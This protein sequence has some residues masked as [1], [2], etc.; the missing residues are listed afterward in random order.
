MDSPVKALKNILYIGAG[1]VGSL[2]AIT[3][4]VQNPQINFVVY[5]I[6]KCLIDQWNKC[7]QS[8]NGFS[9]PFFEP[10]LNEYLQKAVRNGN[11]QF[12]SSDFD[13]IFFKCEAIFVCVN[14]PPLLEGSESLG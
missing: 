10:N 2:S 14:T 5:D 11:L 12:K 8:E 6:N 1:Y 3:M 9:A 4:A 13:E 7:S